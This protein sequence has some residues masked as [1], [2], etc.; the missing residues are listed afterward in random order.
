MG[1]GQAQDAA[2]LIRDQLALM[3]LHTSS[4]ASTLF[5]AEREKRSSSTDSPSLT[6]LI[7]SGMASFPKLPLSNWYFYLPPSWICRYLVDS[8]FQRASDQYKASKL[9][10]CYILST[11]L[12]E[13]VHMRCI[14]K[15]EMYSTTKMQA[16][17]R[18]LSTACMIAISQICLW[19]SSESLKLK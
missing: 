19:L 9:G 2:F 12:G 16:C 17:M 5:T 13:T 18:F 4:V 6:I 3:L 14:F 15:T 1:L 11:L 8:A 10:K 7:L